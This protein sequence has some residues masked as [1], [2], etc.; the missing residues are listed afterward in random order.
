MG[1]FL[2]GF[3]PELKTPDIT[4]MDSQTATNSILTT[5]MA[6][7]AALANSGVG[8]MNTVLDSGGKLMSAFS[9]GLQAY[10]GLKALGVMEDELDMKKEKH[11]ASMQE[12]AFLRKA[13]SRITKSYF[14]G[15]NN[16]ATSRL[17][18]RVG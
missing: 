9:T 14:A 12:I 5:K 4:G 13:R 10:T 7:D 17:A 2:E 3:F 11:A 8:K 16:N 15:N 18:K 6:N 1:N